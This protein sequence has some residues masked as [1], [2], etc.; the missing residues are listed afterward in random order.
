MSIQIVHGYSNPP[1]EGGAN[2]QGFGRYA[3][4]QY[5]YTFVT[6]E[7]QGNSQPEDDAFTPVEH[8]NGYDEEHEHPYFNR[9]VRPGL[10][11]PGALG[12]SSGGCCNHSAMGEGETGGS[13]LLLGAGLLAAAVMFFKKS[14]RSRRRSR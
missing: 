3:G 8:W 14:K 7:G 9:K 1:A 4:T 10:M 5:G 2:Y 13:G 11:V 6:Q 12:R